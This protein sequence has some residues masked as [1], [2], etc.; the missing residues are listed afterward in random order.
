MHWGN[1]IKYN[2]DK[3]ISRTK[4]RNCKE[5]QRMLA[6]MEKDLFDYGCSLEL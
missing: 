2:E 5:Y 6:D 3:G 4:I 1:R